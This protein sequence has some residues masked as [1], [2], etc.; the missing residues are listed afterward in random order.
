MY[1]PNSS[2][3]IN[4]VCEANSALTPGRFVV[5]SAYQR[6]KAAHAMGACG[7]GILVSFK[8][9]FTIYAAVNTFFFIR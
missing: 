4:R 7:H 3:F 9:L 6:R 8:G 2:I 1:Y 5:V